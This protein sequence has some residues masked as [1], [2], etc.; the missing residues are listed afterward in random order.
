MTK[1]VNQ[2]NRIVEHTLEPQTYAQL[3]EIKKI[4]EQVNSHRIDKEN[5]PQSILASWIALE[6]L[7]PQT[8]KKPEDLANGKRENIINLVH[9]DLPWLHEQKY[10]KNHKLYYQLSLGSLSM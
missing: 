3:A 2:Y 6:A 9:S 5:D 4:N 7:A 1:T 10:K 8:Y